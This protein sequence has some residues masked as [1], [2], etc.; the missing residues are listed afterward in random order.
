MP[1]EAKSGPLKKLVQVLS[2]VGVLL[3]GVG[4]ALSLQMPVIKRLWTGSITL[5]AAGKGCFFC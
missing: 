5:T 2:V 4:D 3:I 1:K